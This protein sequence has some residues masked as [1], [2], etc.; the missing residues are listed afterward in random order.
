[1]LKC[2]ECNLKLRIADGSTRS[3]E[4]YGDISVAFRSG[5]GLVPVLITSAA[6]VPDLRYHV[7][8][9]PTLVEND[10]TFSKDAFRT[11]VVRR[12]KSERSPCFR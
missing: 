11:G 9:L 10:H 5:N 12:L 6:H 8:S 1:M 3:T 4:L 2:Q 7:F